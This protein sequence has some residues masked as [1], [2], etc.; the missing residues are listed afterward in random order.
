[1]K[2]AQKN[3]IRVLIVDDDID[4]CV[5]LTGHIEM[6]ADMECCGIAHDG[7]EALRM[8]DALQPDVV[9]LDLVMP[10][11]DGLGVLEY[12]TE[13]SGAKRPHF[14]VS[15]AGGQEHI[16]REAMC[17]GADYF[18]E[19]PYDADVL[20]RRIR[21]INQLEYRKMKPDESDLQKTIA[22][23][24]IAIGIPTNL[25]GYEYI[26]EALQILLQQT[27][28][29]PIFKEIYASIAQR[30][31]SDWRCVENA[32]TSAVKAAMENHSPSLTKA[33]M[34]SPVKL[35]NNALSNGK[36]LTLIAQSIRLEK[37]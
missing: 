17:C 6:Q 33:L 14:L 1:M 25:L 34:F 27:E 15:S 5:V 36:F 22:E 18:P 9:L 10:M 11:L 30:H 12:T 4:F 37:I 23:Q 20:A 29:R 26:Q 32:I 13:H 24:V 19:K 28:G 16:L 8:I 3:K 31:S 35:E 7:K 21:F 2:E